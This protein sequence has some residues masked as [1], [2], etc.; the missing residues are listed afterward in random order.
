MVEDQYAVPRCALVC[1]GA[2]ACITGRNEEKTRDM[3]QDIEKARE[4]STVLPLIVDIRNG[5]DM[6]AAIER[7]K[8]ELG[9]IDF[10]M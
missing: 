6:A 5:K 8:A 4:G 1:L 10:V 3:A 7:C 2:N 9:S